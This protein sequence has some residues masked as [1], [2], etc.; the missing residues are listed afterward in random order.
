MQSRLPLYFINSAAGLL[1][2]MAALCL[3]GNLA[4]GTLTQPHDPVSGMSM[5]TVLWISGAAALAGS[6]VCVFS[7]GALPKT[8]LIAWLSLNFVIYGLGFHWVGA[9]GLGSYLGAIAGPFGISTDV[10][11]VI[12]T[13]AWLYL[14][15]GSSLLLAWS[16][17]QQITEKKAGYLKIPCSSCGSKIKFPP[18]NVGRQ[19]ACPNCRT[20]IT[21][22]KPDENLKM[23]CVLCGGHIEFP[24]HA[25]GQKISC[26]HCAKTIT[27]LQPT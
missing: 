14:L 10:A 5:R 3:V 7:K 15:A 17:L 11:G 9:H 2:A 8:A 21:L 16:G 18:V 12:I 23:T 24:A 13:V 20:V 25:I 26:P 6:L 1:A 27:L 22:R 19:I 4:T